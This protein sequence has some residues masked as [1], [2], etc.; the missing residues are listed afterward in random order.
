[1]KTMAD[2][3]GANMEE[4]KSKLKDIDMKEIET[5]MKQAMLDGL[6]QKL[7]A[8]PDLDPKMKGEL[9]TMV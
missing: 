4:I 2:M 5:K 9:S 8:I 1:M 3:A 7:D 6:V